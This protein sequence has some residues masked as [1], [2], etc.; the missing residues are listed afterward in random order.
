[1]EGAYRSLE[2]TAS[3]ALVPI[4]RVV[5]GFQPAEAEHEAPTFWGDSGAE[6]GGSHH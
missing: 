4:G 6:V 3:C 1:M 5:A 2:V